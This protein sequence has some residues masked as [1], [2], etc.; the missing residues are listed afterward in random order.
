M[1]KLILIRHAKS[2]WS[3]DVSDQDRPLTEKGI[4]KTEKIS[5]ASKKIFFNAKIYTNIHRDRETRLRAARRAQRKFSGAQRKLSKP[6]R[7]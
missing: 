1:K 6:E 5:I 3:L 4:R 2:S 7:K